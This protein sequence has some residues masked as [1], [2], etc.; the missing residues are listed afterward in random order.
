M[1]SWVFEKNR[2]R[3][4]RIFCADKIMFSDQKLL[5]LR[6]F[7]C[8]A[9]IVNGCNTKNDQLKSL[10]EIKINIFKLSETSECAEKGY[11]KERKMNK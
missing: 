5:L 6:A 9:T 4:G 3:G 7:D 1:N 2:K 8:D 11:N 10:G